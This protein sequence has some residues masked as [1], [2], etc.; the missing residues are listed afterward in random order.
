ML[1]DATVD[2]GGPGASVAAVGLEALEDLRG[3]FAGGGEHEHAAAARGRLAGVGEHPVD[4]RQGEGGRLAGAS[5]CAAKEVAAGE[6]V[7]DGLGLDRRGRGVALVGERLEE[8][9]REAEIGKG[10]GAGGI[11]NNGSGHRESLRTVPAADMP[12]GGA[13]E[14]KG[15]N[16]AVRLTDTHRDPGDGSLP[17]GQE[18]FR[19]A[20]GAR[21]RKTAASRDCDR[22]GRAQEKSRVAAFIVSEHPKNS[23]RWWQKKGDSAQGAT[24]IAARATGA[25]APGRGRTRPRRCGPR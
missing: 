21:P 10:R 17:A 25:K 5:L 16:G 12:R 19:G 9:G 7:G 4:Q 22:G 2:H 1:A 13:D 8:R 18:G 23:T 24:V 6:D 15:W 14:N 11:A 20:R 3:E